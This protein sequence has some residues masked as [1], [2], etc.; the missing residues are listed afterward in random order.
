MTKKKNLEGFFNRPENA[1]LVL[2][3]KK[4]VSEKEFLEGIVENSEYK[5]EDIVGVSF[6]NGYQKS[7]KGFRKVQS[8]E[9][10][11]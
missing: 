2:S 6:L 4:R 11:F 8:T 10:Y 3:N 9:D 7:N 5:A 1:Q